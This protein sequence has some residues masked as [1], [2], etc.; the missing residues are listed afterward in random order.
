MP[1]VLSVLLLSLL[2]IS[3]LLGEL[4]SVIR[5]WR[6]FHE[7]GDGVAEPGECGAAKEL[8]AWVTE[9][10][11]CRWLHGGV[12]VCVGMVGIGAIGNG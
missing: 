7:N 3:V 4:L 9:L 10:L 1:L 6:G 5:N 2:L 8:L 11:R 12:T